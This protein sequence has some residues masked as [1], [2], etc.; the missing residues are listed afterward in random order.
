MEMDGGAEGQGIT[1]L[2]SLEIW[3]L[4]GKSHGPPNMA[5]SL[6]HYTIQ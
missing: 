2:K 5:A 3:T 6:E 4:V 1:K